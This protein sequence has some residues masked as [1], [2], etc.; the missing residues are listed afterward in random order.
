MLQLKRNISVNLILHLQKL[1]Y[2]VPLFLSFT[3]LFNI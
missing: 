1:L 2:H 3:K